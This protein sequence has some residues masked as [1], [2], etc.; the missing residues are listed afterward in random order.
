MGG[1]LNR[2]ISLVYAPLS[3]NVT[4]RVLLIHVAF[5]YC[6]P[7]AHWFCL[8]PSLEDAFFSS[9]PCLENLVFSLFH[10]SVLRDYTHTV[11]GAVGIHHE[12]NEEMIKEEKVTCGCCF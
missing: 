3:Y 8:L 7:L 6:G 9:I 12:V 11:R 2:V 10:L 5:S 1:V 4:L